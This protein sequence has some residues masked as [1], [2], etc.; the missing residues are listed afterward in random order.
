MIKGIENILNWLTFH[1]L[2]LENIDFCSD[3]PPYIFDFNHNFD[4]SFHG[5]ES[6][7]ETS[8]SIQETSAES[9]DLS[10]SSGFHETLSECSEFTTDLSIGEFEFDL[11]REFE[12]LFGGEAEGETG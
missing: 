3:I 11:E 8:F 4:S 2:A 10:Q 5:E 9:C 7:S 6:E 12:L 1:T